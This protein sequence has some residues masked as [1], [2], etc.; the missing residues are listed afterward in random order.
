MQDKELTQGIE[1]LIEMKDM[2]EEPELQNQDVYLIPST[3]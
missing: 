1:E 3:K 2:E